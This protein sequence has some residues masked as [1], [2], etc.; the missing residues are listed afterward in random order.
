MRIYHVNSAQDALCTDG[1]VQAGR[2]SLLRLAFIPPCQA[3]RPQDR[4]CVR[5]WSFSRQEMVTPQFVDRHFGAYCLYGSIGSCIPCAKMPPT[6]LSRGAV[7][8]R[9]LRGSPFRRMSDAKFASHVA[10]SRACFGFP[11]EISFRTQKV[12]D[13]NSVIAE[14]CLTT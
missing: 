9:L 8:G 11:T 4:N 3:T 1:K 6:R 10:R 2:C 7:F 13:L 5:N 12:H 14:K